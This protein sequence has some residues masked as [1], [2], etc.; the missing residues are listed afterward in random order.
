VLRKEPEKGLVEPYDVQPQ[1]WVLKLLSDTQVPVPKVYWLETD[2]NVLGK[3]FFVMDW[4]EGEVPIPFN[5]HR[6]EYYKNPDKRKQMGKN[7]VEVLAKIHQ[8]DW[9]AL[10]LDR[11][12]RMPEEEKEPAR[13]EIERWEN[14]LRDFKIG[15]E[16]VLVEVLLWL[17][18]N[19]PATKR[20]TLVHGDYRLGNFIWRNNHIVAFLDWEMAWIGDPISDLGWLCI[21]DWSPHDPGMACGLLDI[22]EVCKYYYKLTGVKVNEEELHFWTI[23]GNVKLAALHICGARSYLDRRTFDLRML[24]P[25]SIPW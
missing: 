5:L 22:E 15:P 9:K 8:V 7:L 18:E 1:Y 10:G 16:P 11:H 24:T 17:K 19:V 13:R 25:N 2:P 12:L 4:I 20:P 3:P 6:Q 21:R 14:I 23:M